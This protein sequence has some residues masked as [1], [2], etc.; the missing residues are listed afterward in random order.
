MEVSP[1][2]IQKAL[3]DMDYPAKKKDIIAH[4]KKHKA[5]SE[6][7]N[8]LERIEDKEYRNAVDVSKEFKGE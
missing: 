8:E 3:K 2:K 7:L 5:S 6:V 1:I 4:A